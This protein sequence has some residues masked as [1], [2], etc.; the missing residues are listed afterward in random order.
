[1]KI[2]LGIS[3]IISSY[4]QAQEVAPREAARNIYDRAISTE[5]RGERIDAI[6]KPDFL[7]PLKLNRDGTFPRYLDRISLGRDLLLQ[8]NDPQKQTKIQALNSLE[9]TFESNNR[10]LLLEIRRVRS[11]VQKSLEGIEYSQNITENELNLRAIIAILDKMAEK[12]DGGNDL[13]VTGKGEPKLMGESVRNELQSFAAFKA[14]AILLSKLAVWRKDIES[15]EDRNSKTNPRIVDAI[16]PNNGLR[17]VIPLQNGSPPIVPFSHLDSRMGRRS[18][19]T[20]MK[21]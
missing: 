18:L 16:K 11:S 4:L 12:I 20:N 3:L 2:L 17:R 15:Q 21:Y 10:E 1:M 19:P 7:G 8:G 5:I 6:L 13:S 9:K 14:Q